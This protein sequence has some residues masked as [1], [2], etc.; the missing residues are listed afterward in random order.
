M[1]TGVASIADISYTKR[2]YKNA[3]KKSVKSQK[4][5]KKKNTDFELSQEQD[6][7]VERISPS[8]SDHKQKGSR[9]NSKSKKMRKSQSY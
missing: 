1:H 5:Q 8:G 3:S 4:K 7:S 6:D 2:M 9:S